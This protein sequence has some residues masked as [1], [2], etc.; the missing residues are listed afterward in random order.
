MLPSESLLQKYKN[1]FDQ[2]PGFPD[3]TLRWMNS[4]AEK[5]NCDKCGGIVL[6]EMSV[7]E[8][9]SVEFRGDKM[10]IVGLVNIGEAANAM[11]QKSKNGNDIRLASHILQFIFLGYD[12][13]RFPFG[14][15]PTRGAN[16]PEL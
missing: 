12:G 16:A 7:Q 8:D 1:C 11:Y 10:N 5:E 6:D 3:E 2:Q 14:Y 13:F 9:M 4:E 15:L